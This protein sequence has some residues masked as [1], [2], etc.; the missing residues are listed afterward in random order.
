[1]EPFWHAPE[2]Y[3]EGVG[4]LLVGVKRISQARTS[5]ILGWAMGMGFLLAFPL[6][7]S[8]FWLRIATEVL[9][10]AGL[11]QSWNII[12]GYTG[13]LSFGHGAFFGIGAYATAI[14]MVHAGWPFW[15]TLLVGAILSALCA[16]AVGFPTLRLRG[17]YFA[18]ATWAFG[19]AMRQ[20]ATVLE[21]TGGAFGMQLPPFLNLPFFYEAM[22]IATVLTYLLAFLL[23]ERSM[24][25]YKLRAIRENEV[26]AEAAGV[27]TVVTKIEAF[28]LSAIPAAVFGGLYAYLIT[29]IHPD[30]V[31]GPAI[32]DLMVVMVLFGGVGTLW[33]PLVGATAIQLVNRLLWFLRGESTLYLVYAGVAICLVVLF[34]PDGLLGLVERR[35]LVLRP[36]ENLRALL[37]QFKL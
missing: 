21:A 5:Q 8:S 31:L 7:V 23:L 19:E 17:A 1:M 9:M 16:A 20:V 32:T 26:A 11:A 10:W 13:Y 22:L 27:D 37:R 36:K 29:Y 15:P 12:G 34:M 28:I 6:F 18:I 24:F 33:G 30:S 2:A 25:G 14:L 4:N 35:R 3:S